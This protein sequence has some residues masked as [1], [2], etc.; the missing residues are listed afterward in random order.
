MKEK[1]PRLVLNVQNQARQS[2]AVVWAA[3]PVR[4]A[5]GFDDPA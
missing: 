2:L 4:F 1:E 3:R 5:R